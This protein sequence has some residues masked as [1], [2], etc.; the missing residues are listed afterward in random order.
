MFIKCQIVNGCKAPLIT[1]RMYIQNMILGSNILSLSFWTLYGSDPLYWPTLMT[2]EWPP[3]PSKS[4][5]GG[6]FS[7]INTSP[8]LHQTLFFCFSLRRSYNLLSGFL[9]SDKSIQITQT[10]L[11][12]RLFNLIICL[13]FND[14]VCSLMMDKLKW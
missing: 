8:S 13:I 7:T 9:P 2:I 6:Y 11:H 5:R 4:D 1:C 12:C 14:F 10:V 3:I